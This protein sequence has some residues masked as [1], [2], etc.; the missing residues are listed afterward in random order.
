MGLDNYFRTYVGPGETA[1]TVTIDPPASLCG[2]LFSSAKNS[3]SFRGKAY[4]NFVQETTGKSLYEDCISSRTVVEMAD[5][6]AAWI[7]EHPNK[8][9]HDNKYD[10]DIEH[11]EIIDLERVFRVYGDADFDLLSWW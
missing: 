6:I 3:S 1:P 4:D 5:D 10:E 11:A 2:G 8:D 7:K 9:F